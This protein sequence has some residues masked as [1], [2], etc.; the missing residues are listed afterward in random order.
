[1][2]TCVSAATVAALLLVA[3]GAARADRVS[4]KADIEARHAYA[5][6]EARDGKAVTHIYLFDRAPPAKAWDDA[7]NR[8]SEITAWMLQEKAPSVHWELDDKNAPDSIMACNAEGMCSSRGVNVINDIPSA[9]AELKTGNGR[10]AGKLLEGSGACGDQWCDVLGSYEID[11][12]LAPAPLADRVAA[13]GTANGAGADAARA[14]LAKYWTAAGKAKASND[15]LPYF[16]SQRA[17]DAKRQA[18]RNGERGEAMFKA[19]FVPAHAG[20]LDITS[21]KLLDDAALARIKTRAGSGKDSWD[22]ECNVLL[23]KEADAWKIGTED[24]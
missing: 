9:R 20:K 24:C 4:G 23:R 5:W 15:L 13:K 11:I 6:T 17:A 8:S 22:L 18:E 1:M 12:A 3:S 10:L 19:M 7:E 16:S 2:R 14:A 21:I